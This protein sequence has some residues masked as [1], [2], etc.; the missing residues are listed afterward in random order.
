MRSKNEYVRVFKAFSDE[1]RVRVL[2]LLQDEEK[3]ACIL[4]EDLNINQS[5]LSHHMKILC[6]SGI[7]KSRP[8]GKWSYY[9]INDSGCSYARELLI[10][11]T[12]RKTAGVNLIT[13]V[14]N[15]A[16]FL[17]FHVVGKIWICRW[18]DKKMSKRLLH[19][20]G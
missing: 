18:H 9:S 5:T 19:I 20:G 17:F 7:V 13:H 8:V 15:K 4:L 10:R 11:L 12:E 6:E 3:C 1:N 2:E 16:P 14:L